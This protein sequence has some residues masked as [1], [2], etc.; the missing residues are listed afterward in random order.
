MG[1]ELRL[2]LTQL[3][4]ETANLDLVVHPSE[5]LQRPVA[6]PAGEIARPV[7]PCAGSRRGRI[8]HEPLR[9]H[10]RLA[11]IAPRHPRTANPDLATD[12]DR[13]RISRRVADPDR[14]V[15]KRPADPRDGRTLSRRHP[16]ARGDDRRFGRTVENSQL[17]RR[18]D[19]AHPC[20]QLRRHRVAAHEKR[21]QPREARLGPLGQV[22]DLR[23][24][25]RY[26]VQPRHRRQQRGY[27]VEVQ[28]GREPHQLAPA[29]HQQRAEQLKEEDVE[30]ERRQT[31]H[32][33]PRLPT[34]L[35]EAR[36]QRMDELPLLDHHPLR[37]AG[38]TRGVDHVGEGARPP[39]RTLRI[40]GRR[41]LPESRI[42]QG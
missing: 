19:L 7:G 11:E 1:Q 14:D 17:C 15:G 37:L 25:R 6:A 18:E 42:V 23:H 33:V 9:G 39:S 29:P 31:G 41:P 21:P 20:Q 4:A 12:S 36:R 35:A 2:D 13:N 26:G 27:P 10:S 32:T 5:E 38:R 28:R 34:E 24:Q 16:P 30:R 8:G 40:A 3:D 22:H